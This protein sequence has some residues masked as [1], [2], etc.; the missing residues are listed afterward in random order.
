M[1]F[2]EQY[3]VQLGLKLLYKGIKCVFQNC[4]NF[5]Y[6]TIHTIL[7]FYYRIKILQFIKTYFQIILIVIYIEF[8]TGHKS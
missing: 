3:N 4:H 5:Y 1:F 6:I 8:S 2:S 7:V